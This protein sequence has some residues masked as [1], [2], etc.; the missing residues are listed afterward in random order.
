MAEDLIRKFHNLFYEFIVILKD[1]DIGECSLDTAVGIVLEMEKVFQAHPTYHG[2]HEPE[3]EKA[4][5]RVMLKAKH[6]EEVR[7]LQRKRRELDDKLEALLDHQV[8][9]NE[10]VR[11]D[12]DDRHR[13][14]LG[15]KR[16]AESTDE[17][18]TETESESETSS[19]K[20][21]KKDMDTVKI[22]TES[23]DQPAKAT[24]Q[25]KRKKLKEDMVTV[26]TESTD[27]QEIQWETEK[28]VCYDCMHVWKKSQG[29][30]L[31]PHCRSDFIVIL[32]PGKS[33]PWHGDSD[34]AHPSPSPI[35][36]SAPLRG[37]PSGHLTEPKGDSLKS[38]RKATRDSIASLMTLSKKRSGIG[39]SSNTRKHLHLQEKHHA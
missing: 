14:T 37:N 12:G 2:R 16:Y 36:K 19:C 32:E 27:Q 26:K 3:L 33:D 7:R 24:Q 39:S 18:D 22:K 30:L 35:Q 4:K 17:S 1:S 34:I 21:L 8:D 15:R 20:K 28:F 29:G 6:M 11:G 5:A 38:L 13:S 23:T 10:S 9:H 25:N 31:C